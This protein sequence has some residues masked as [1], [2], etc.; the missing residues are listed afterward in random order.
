M[1]GQDLIGLK[2]VSKD[3]FAYHVYREDDTV[4][5]FFDEV[6]S[7]NNY[8]YYVEVMKWLYNDQTQMMD[9]QPLI[10]MASNDNLSVKDEARK[11]SVFLNI[12]GTKSE[13]AS[14]ST[15]E[16][17]G[18]KYKKTATVLNSFLHPKL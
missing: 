15:L 12:D 17:I 18:K 6:K 13:K 14:A 9:K 8:R 4:P 10:I 5:I 2:P 3:V 11:R 1:T 7:G 16:S